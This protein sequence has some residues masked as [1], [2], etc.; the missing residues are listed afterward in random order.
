[1]ATADISISEDDMPPPKDCMQK[2][3]SGRGQ[4]SMG[5]YKI[6]RR[7]RTAGE[8]QES[9]GQSPNYTGLPGFNQG[10]TK[11]PLGN[12]DGNQ[13][14]RDQAE[15][16]PGHHL[17]PG[18]PTLPPYIPPLASQNSQLCSNSPP[19]A[20]RGRQ[21]SHQGAVVCRDN[22]PPTT[23]G[24]VLLRHASVSRPAWQSHGSAQG[25]NLRSHSMCA[26]SD[27]RITNQRSSAICKQ[28]SG[29][30]PELQADGTPQGLPDQ[31]RLPGRIQILR[32][33]T[34]K[35]GPD[36]YRLNAQ[37]AS[38][39]GPVR[40][41]TQSVS[42]H[43]S[44]TPD[45]ANPVTGVGQDLYNQTVPEGP[46]V[47]RSTSGSYPDI[48]KNVSSARPH[49]SKKSGLADIRVH[50][51]KLVSGPSLHGQV[52]KE[53]PDV[54][55]QS[56]ANTD[57]HGNA[58]QASLNL[59]NQPTQQRPFLQNSESEPSSYLHDQVPQK[60]SD[61]HWGSSHLRHR[62]QHQPKYTTQRNSDLSCLATLP[63][64][65][66]KNSLTRGGQD[67]KQ[68]SREGHTLRSSGQGSHRDVRSH[69][70]W[71]GLDHYN[72]ATLSGNLPKSNASGTGTDLHGQVFQICAD[73]YQ[74]GPIRANS[75]LSRQA[76]PSYRHLWQLSTQADCGIPSHANRKGLKLH[77]NASVSFDDIW[78]YNSQ[79]CNQVMLR[80]PLLHRYAGGS[81][82]DTPGKECQHDL[83]CHPCTICETSDLIGSVSL[84][85]DPD[86]QW[87]QG[88]HYWQGPTESSSD[89]SSHATKAASDILDPLILGG[90]EHLQQPSHEGLVLPSSVSGS[91]HNVLYQTIC[92]GP[93]LLN[94]GTLP[95]HVQ[96]SGT[97]TSDSAV[98]DQVFKGCPDH[99]LCLVWGSSDHHQCVTPSG[100]NPWDL[101][102]REGPDVPSLATQH[103]QIQYNSSSVSHRD[104]SLST[105]QEGPDLCSQVSDHV[106]PSI[107]SRSQPDVLSHATLGGQDL[108]KST[109]FSGTSIRRNVPGSHADVQSH[110]ILAQ[111]D[112]QNWV[113]VR[114]PLLHSRA[115]SSTSACNGPT[116]RAN[117][118]QQR[119]YTMAAANFQG[120]TPPG[121]PDLVNSATPSGLVFNSSASMAGHDFHGHV[122]YAGQDA[123]LRVM[124][125]GQVLWNIPFDSQHDVGHSNVHA[126]S[127]LKNWATLPHHILRIHA[128]GPNPEF[129]E[130]TALSGPH[131]PNWSHLPYPILWNNAS[132]S[133]H[134]IWSQ[135]PAQGQGLHPFPILPHP[136]PQSSAYVSQHDLLSHSS[137]SGLNLP[138]GATLPVTAVFSKASHSISDLSS[139]TTQ[140]CSNQQY[141]HTMANLEF[142]FPTTSTPGRETLDNLGT[143]SHP[144]FSRNSSM[145]GHYFHENITCAA[146]DTVSR[147]TVPG[148]ILPNRGMRIDPNF[149]GCV[150]QSSPNIGIQANETGPQHCNILSGAGLDLCRSTSI[151]H[152]A[153][154]YH[155]T[156]PGPRLSCFSTVSGPNY[157]RCEPPYQ[158]SQQFLLGPVPGPDVGGSTTTTVA[159][160]HSQDNPPR[161]AQGS[162]AIKE[163]SGLH[164]QVNHQAAPP[165]M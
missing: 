144:V 52:L 153:P 133:H 65:G 129:Q 36:L 13:S 62:N 16:P 125:P 27:L 54:H 128:C 160:Q 97:S 41:L 42:D 83:N 139:C 108:E 151:P 77:R 119:C 78:C 63:S 25:P 3:H 113:S 141:G 38:N 115:S 7:P 132:A 146:Q 111:R 75:E 18:A 5:P 32:R 102:T 85:E 50:K 26:G 156:V 110:A 89:L 12:F 100:L 118:D 51:N 49:L 81:G 47:C 164:S 20:S 96:E 35:S 163:W 123:S 84:E 124:N 137:Q 130:Q 64:P 94:P 44:A 76:A 9:V 92:R 68:A 101:S 136:V 99:C 157:H 103:D 148:H 116:T 109:T 15:N 149:H 79:D 1:M 48:L 138:N 28:A 17:A 142:Q 59:C 80:G 93:N 22:T 95:G 152:S 159:L 4:E 135:H 162:Q 56:V 19:K 161:A 2:V 53:R 21:S 154:A 147:A 10:K 29:K 45:A 60:C 8:V 67:L 143:P 73:R 106:L 107:S 31:V 23:P 104:V 74:Q 57:L 140:A 11:N 91:H 39:G 98:F 33:N 69:S 37:K 71:G 66:V 165:N 43:A 58:N 87:K 61:R 114:N 117:P 131:H 72:Q 82:S 30:G 121:K 24:G 120:F 105:P 14:S 88:Q 6:L 145:S 122:P 46:I 158:F 34:S 70:T 55:H 40:S 134:I 86:Y 127:N 150:T 126:G 90:Q 112:V 155:S